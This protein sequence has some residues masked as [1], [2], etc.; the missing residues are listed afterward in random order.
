MRTDRRGFL[1][2]GFAA[3]GF[4]QE[5]D[6]AVRVGT[7]NVKACL[8]KYDRMKEVEGEIAALRDRFVRE[9]EELRKKIV[10]LTEQ[11]DQV[12]NA[13]A[14]YF[15]A[16]R[17]RG[18]AEYDLKLS[19]EVAQRRVRDLAVDYEARITVDLRRAVALVAP[20][21]NLQLVVRIDDAGVGAREVL[22]H[23]PGLDLTPLVLARL[24]AEWKKAWAC[25][26]CKRKVAEPACRDCRKP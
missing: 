1:A 26:T 3:A 18:H 24:N 5:R 23:E 20:D 9:G 2:T 21:R 7:V 14:A 8:E 17:L 15:E 16:V 25:P 10:L 12:K 22:Y 6:G 19:Q 4:G 13:P 11:L